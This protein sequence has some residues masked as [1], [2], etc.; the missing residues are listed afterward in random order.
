MQREL[1]WLVTVLLNALKISWKVGLSGMQSNPFGR[2]KILFAF[3]LGSLH[4]TQ[5]PLEEEARSDIENQIIEMRCTS[6]IQWKLHLASNGTC[7]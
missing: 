5:P 1:V 4:C 2:L 6:R 7:L 3:H